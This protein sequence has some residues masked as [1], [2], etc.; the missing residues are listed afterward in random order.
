MMT[1]HDIRPNDRNRSGDRGIAALFFAIS[2]TAMLAVSALVL[3]GS[4]G[5]TASRNAQTAADSAALAGASTL[6]DHKHDWVATP[7][8]AV[9]G[10]V[11]SV[12]EHNGATLAPGGCELVDAAYALTRSDADVIADCVELEFLS[13]ADFAA[14]AGVRVTVLDTRDVP[15]SAF[16]DHQDTITGT[17]VA[18]ATIQPVVEGR[19]PFMM[20]TAPDAVGHPAQALLPSDSDPTGYIVNPGAFG[21]LYV[22]WG[23]QVKYEGRDC[24]NPSSNWRG[25]VN[26]ELAFPVPSADSLDDTYWWQTESGNKNGTLPVTLAG[27]NACNIDNGSVSAITVGCHIA[28]PLCPFGNGDSSDFRLYCVKIGVFEISHVGAVFNED[29]TQLE[30]GTPCGTVT[31]N[32]ICGEFLGVGSA[33]GGRGIAE[34]PDPNSVVVIKLVE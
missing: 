29:V 7:S 24:G 16:I 26:F 2:V 13:K 22:L 4:I 31:S 3:G 19:S 28:V 30:E 34:T 33:I 27:D 8:S 6:R 18:T 20:C 1:S 21:K 5:Y 14:T 25:L 17:A 12:V 15:F 32:I 10:T 23:N 9:E 11:Q